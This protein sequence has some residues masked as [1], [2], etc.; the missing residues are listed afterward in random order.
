MIVSIFGR[1][2]CGK[3]T[4]SKL[5]AIEYGGRVIFFS[6]VESWEEIHPLEFWTAQEIVEGLPAMTAG[7]VAIIRRAELPYFDLVACLVMVECDFTLVIDEIE[8][9]RA[10]EE[11][12][13][14]IHYARHFRINM[15]CNTRR[16]TDTPRLLT[17]QS[18]EIDVFL[19]MEPRDL[20]YLAEY[21]TAS[22]EIFQSLPPFSYYSHPTGEIK[23]VF[24][25]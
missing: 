2:G 25:V 17:S 1:K 3:S 12:E 8:H 9:F 14:L 4:L 7:Q 18:D 5:K 10:S 23:K 11:L 24:P 6:P 19:T 21:T 15:I 16:Y 20:A 13:T 22:T